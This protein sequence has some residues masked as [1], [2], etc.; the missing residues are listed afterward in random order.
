MLLDSQLGV[1]IARIDLPFLSHADHLKSQSER[2]TDSAAELC[3]EVKPH[4]ICISL[5]CMLKSIIWV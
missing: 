2:R 1:C 4:E 5:I 3:S